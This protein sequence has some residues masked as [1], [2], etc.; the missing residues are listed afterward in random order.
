[1]EDKIKKRQHLENYFGE[2]GLI[3]TPEHSDEVLEKTNI[4]LQHNP[5]LKQKYKEL[6]WAYNSIWQI[7]PQTIENFWSGHTFPHIQSYDEFQISFNLLFFGFYKQ[8]FVSLRS[9]LELG[10]LSVYYNINDLGHE[11][12]KNWLK[13]QNSWDSNTPKAEKI[14]KILNSNSNIKRFN[15]KYDL[16]K[17]FEALSFLHNYVHSK[18]WKYSNRLGLMKPNYQTFEE[19]IV[20]KWLEVYKDIIILLITL[21]ILKYPI[22]II[23]YDWDKKVGIDNPFPVLEAF[24]I[25]A[26]EALL[27]AGYSEELRNIAQNDILT[28][29]LL[30]YILSLPDMSEEEIALQISKLNNQMV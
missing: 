27:P 11:T 15:E 19:S 7:I 16:Q 28:Q 4:F 12:V 5:D 22:S 21:H 25:E 17:K 6:N 18:G 24:E 23:K 13:S 14:W 10:L 2:F 30:L 8:S 26:I 29:E 20:L 3:Y 9:G 1:M